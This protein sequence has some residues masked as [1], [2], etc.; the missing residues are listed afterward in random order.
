[1]FHKVN[2]GSRVQMVSVTSNDRCHSLTIIED[3]A[4]N[5]SAAMSFVL[6][7]AL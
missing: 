2:D 5:Y 7:R 1:M 4:E 6:Q 3:L